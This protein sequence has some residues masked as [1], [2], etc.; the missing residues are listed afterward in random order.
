MKIIK[1]DLDKWR[2]NTLFMYQKTKYCK[3]EN[4]FPT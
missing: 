1:E 4:S 2:D 3:D